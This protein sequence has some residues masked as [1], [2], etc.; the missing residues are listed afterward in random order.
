MF[1]CEDDDEMVWYRG[2]VVLV[3]KV[4]EKFKYNILFDDNEKVVDM[5]RKVLFREK[6]PQSDL[7]YQGNKF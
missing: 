7:Q 2:E 6:P 1:Y 4:G 5:S 3:K